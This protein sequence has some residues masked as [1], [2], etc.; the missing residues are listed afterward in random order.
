MPARPYPE[1]VAVDL[2]TTGLDASKD[3]IIE[4]GAVRFGREGVLDRFQTL[5][6]PGVPIPP[7]IRLMTSITDEDVRDAPPPARA[8]SEFAVFAGGRPLVGHNVAFDLGFLMEA[9]APMP[10]PSL[11]TYELASVLLPTSDRLDLGSLA[12][13]LG[14]R[15][16]QHH[17]ALPDAEATAEVML[18][19]LDRLDALSSRA[20]RDLA[21]LAARAEW[22][23]APLFE[24]AL[25][26]RA[27]EGPAS[28]APSTLGRPVPDPLPPVLQ[29]GAPEEP[30][31]VDDEDVERLFEEPLDV[32]VVHRPRLLG[33][34]ELQH[35]WQRVGHGPAQRR[36]RTARGPLGGAGGEGVLEQRGERP[37]GA[38]SE[39]GEV[40][41][42]ARGERVEAVEEPQHYLGRRLSVRERAVVLLQPHAQRG[43]EGAEVEPVGRGQ[44]HRRQL[45]RVEAGAGHRRA[46]LHEEAEVEGDVVADER[47]ASGEDGELGDGAR[48]RRSVAHVLVGDRGHEPDAGR[49][50][51]AGPHERLEAVEHALAPKAHRADLDDAVL[52]GVEAGGLEVDGDK[53]GVGPGRH[54]DTGRRGEWSWAGSPRLTR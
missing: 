21:S 23:L 54:Q 7:G 40:S 35:G 33:R 34:A 48:G 27:T 44:Q 53:L 1:F 30:R 32:F 4:I 14:V 37:L 6:R 29:L 52:R 8:V 15:L 46:R 43:G 16:E 38:R 50:R 18:R 39:R 13:A 5:V 19:L 3:R 25:A 2:E 26:A 11:D 36:R 12:A 42:G 17:R 9:G 28:G 45:V 47:A 10:G 22:A 41:Q 24:D 51:H 20:L 31:T 49:D